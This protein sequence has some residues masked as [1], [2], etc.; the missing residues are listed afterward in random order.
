MHKKQSSYGKLASVFQLAGMLGFS[1]VLVACGVN[2]V[3]KAASETPSVTDIAVTAVSSNVFV[4]GSTTLQATEGGEPLAGG[5]WIVVGGNSEG[6]ITPAG[7]YTAPSVLP[8]VDAVTIQ[9]TR[10]GVVGSAVLHITNPI[11]TLTAISPASLTQLS[12]PVT[13]SG[14]GFVAGSKV[15]VG[16]TALL[17]TFLD[18]G[19]LSATVILSQPENAAIPITVANPAPGASTSNQL[20]LSTVFP[21]AVTALKTIIPIGGSTTLQATEGGFS[22]SNGQ[23]TVVGGASAGSITSTGFYTAP[24]ILPNSNPVTVQFSLNGVTGSASLQIVNPTPVV[25]AISP[26]ALTQLSTPVT[27]SGSGFVPGSQVLINNVAV[28]TTFV[29]ASHL[30][31]TVN[32]PQAQNTTLTVA[33]ANPAPGASTS[34]QLNLGTNFGIQVTASNSAVP[35]GRTTVLQA[36]ENGAAVSGGQWTVIGGSAAGTIDSAGLYTAPAVLP[37]VNPVT[38]Q[39]SLNGVTGSASLQIV[40]PT[41]VVGAISPAALTQLSTPVTISGSGFVPGSQVLINNVAVATTFVDASH[42]A[43]TVNLPQAQNTTLTVAVANPAPGASTSNQLNLGTN[44]GIQVTASNSAVPLGRTTVLQASENGAAVSGG[45]WTVIGGSAAGTIDSAGLYTAPAVLPAVNPVTVQFSLNGVTGSASLQIVNPTPVVGAISPAALTQL[46]TPVTISG[47]G[48][49]PG[50]QVLINNVAVA[51]TFVD[52]SHLAAT[53]NLPQAQNTTLTVAVANPAPGASTSNQ[54]NLGT[55]F[56]TITVSPSTLSSGQLTI[57]ISGTSFPATATAF[58]DGKALATT[59]ISSSSLIATGYLPPWKSGSVNISVAYAPTAT[60]EADVQVPLAPVQ[61]T[62]DTAARFSTQAA[63]G[64]N[65]EVVLHIQQTGLSGFIQEQLQLPGVVYPMDGSGRA[66]RSLF[67]QGATQGMSLLRL[68]SAW[69]LRSYI[70]VPNAGFYAGVAEWEQKLETGA[71]GN[72]R[73]L[74]TAIASD[75]LIG[76]GLNLAGNVAPSDPT[77]HPDQNFAREL[78]QL[79]TLGTTL[80]NDDG[81]PKLDSNGQPLP[82]YDQNTVIELSRIFTGWEL[83]PVVNQASTLWGVDYSQLLVAVESEHD[84]GSKTLFGTT[85]I[86]ANGTTTQ[87]RDL[88][89]NAIFAHPNLPPFVSRILIQKLVKSSPTPAYVQRISDV[90]KDDGNGTRGNLAAVIT[91]ILLDPEAR[92]GDSNPSPDDGFVQEPLLFETFALSALQNSG[93]DDQFSYWPQNIGENFWILPSVFSFYSPSYLIPGTTINSPEF[94]L[95]NNATSV[96]RSQLLWGIV[97]GQQPGLNPNPNAWL[98]QNF[99]DVSSLIE[100]LNHLLYHGTMS[101][102]EQSDI[103]AYCATLDPADLQSQLYSAVFLAMNSDSYTVSH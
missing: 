33:V 30:A 65:P 49:V 93:T 96:H 4:G 103:A 79:F 81:T 52:A 51:T 43:A 48:F 21:V 46:S 88:A 11:P 20:S 27:I 37:A 23:W 84:T 39:F 102:A 63:F 17:T 41:P 76:T 83:H 31:A 53:V 32:L 68:R 56:P 75:P 100:A 74:M 57:T 97:T 7:V 24:S 3:N 45:Q 85:V 16:N 70:D 47:S 54:L 82:T 28:A 10:D 77:Q 2:V 69:A 89:L 71:F 42:L 72:Y 29:D 73:D 55:N 91:A 61:A 18:A 64:P 50:S 25:G 87:D 78:M 62:F 1:S 67:L 22:M 6:S 92:S 8:N 13:V 34:N 99:H 86:P 38:V 26:A 44:F 35:L 94:S 5:E 12:T 40:N 80:L 98:Y 90:F 15:M 66:P 19:H 59:R 36:S 95:L 60:A 58:L 9:Y 14:T 101:P